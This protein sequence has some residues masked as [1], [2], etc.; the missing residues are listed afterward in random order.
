MEHPKSSKSTLLIV[1]DEAQ[2]RE[3]VIDDLRK[4]DL[5]IL[6]AENGEAALKILRSQT[7]HAVLSDIRMPMMDG[8]ALLQKVRDEG[9]M[10]PFVFLTAFS[11]R[12]YFLSALRLSVVDLVEKPY[13]VQDLLRAL[14]YAIHLG[15]QLE[16]LETEVANTLQSYQV[17]AEKVSELQKHLR[18]VLVLQKFKRL[19]PDYALPLKKAA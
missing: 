7:V 14:T 8:L 10:T 4:Y 18:E 15:V 16:N 1:D 12:E 3:M 9:K 5:H 19:E 2:I 13:P 11:E 6:T 17:P